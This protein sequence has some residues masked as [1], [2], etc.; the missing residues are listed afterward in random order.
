MKR[1]GRVDRAKLKGRK[2]LSTNVKKGPPSNEEGTRR[3]CSC[4]TRR[5][6]GG[7]MSRCNRSEVGVMDEDVS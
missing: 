7:G 1:R 2:E 6:G 3:G 4:S 5:G